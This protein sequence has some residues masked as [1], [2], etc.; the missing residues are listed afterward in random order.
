MHVGSLVAALASRC[1]ALASNGRWMLRIDDIDP[2]R[3]VAGASASIIR[4]L[5]RFG[6]SWDGPV[7]YQSERL[8]RYEEA[9]RRLAADGRLYRCRCTRRQLRGLP[10]Y[11]GTCRPPR[12]GTAHD[13]APGDAAHRSDPGEAAADVGAPVLSS[14]PLATPSTTALRVRLDG[15]AELEDG[16]QGTLAGR[17]A[18]TCG[19]VILRRRDGLVAYPLACAVDDA[20]VREVVRGADLLE[21]SIAQQALLE[22]LGS[23]S[24]AWAH[25]PVALDASG[26]KLG[27]STGAP[28]LDE[29]APLPTLLDVWR[30]LGQAPLPVD[31]LDAFWREAP[32]R[33][34]LAAV[35][36]E[37]A[38]PLTT[39][40][41]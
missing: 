6:F 9:L 40:P 17:H 2:P 21:A 33:W 16:V 4:T 31:S 24:P 36:R 3:E 26:L 15:R 27:K 8:A 32:R 13:V 12:G 20:D 29:C 30:F 14:R 34:S 35:P 5:E 28:P 41:A 1:Q 22:L 11:P 7:R 25:V 38:R 10:R 39:P 19:D 18:D 23:G 37:R